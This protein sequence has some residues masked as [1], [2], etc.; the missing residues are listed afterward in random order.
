MSE[1]PTMHTVFRK[2]PVHLPPVR[3]E[4]SLF[5]WLAGFALAVCFLAL[6]LHFY[7]LHKKNLRQPAYKE[8]S[9]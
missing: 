9:R 8:Q 7:T 3:Q 4:N 6:T 2:L 5:W 1:E